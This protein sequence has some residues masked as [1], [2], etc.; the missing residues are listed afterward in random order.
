MHGE[1]RTDRGVA[2]KLIAPP[3]STVADRPTPSIGRAEL[4]AR[5]QPIV[6]VT[7][8]IGVYTL[9]HRMHRSRTILV[10]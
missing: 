10:P 2:P 7:K 6:T 3:S 1:R 4:S 5:K 9:F 8:Q